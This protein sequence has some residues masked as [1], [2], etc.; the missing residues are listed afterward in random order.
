MRSHSVRTPGPSNS[1]LTRPWRC[2]PGFAKED[3]RCSSHVAGNNN[4]LPKRATGHAAT[5]NRLLSRDDD[6]RA[7]HDVSGVSDDLTKSTGCRVATWHLALVSKNLGAVWGAT[8]TCPAREWTPCM[9]VDAHIRCCKDWIVCIRVVPR[10]L[11][12][13]SF[14][15]CWYWFSCRVVC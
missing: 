12:A 7:S 2:I 10:R 5:W 9:F 8:L 13:S 6:T 1:R 11:S 3:G 15:R 4:I 14:A